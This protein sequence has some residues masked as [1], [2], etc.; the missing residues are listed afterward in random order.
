[1]K[2]EGNIIAPPSVW[3]IVSSPSLVGHENME[4]C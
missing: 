3:E 4:F 1:M 2:K